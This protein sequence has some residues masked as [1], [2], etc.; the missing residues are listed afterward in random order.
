[1]IENFLEF[2]KS[3][4]SYA[5]LL[6]QF[7]QNFTYFRTFYITSNSC[8]KSNSQFMWNFLDF[9]VAKQSFFKKDVLLNKIF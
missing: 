7:S 5:E 1:M 4:H 6:N 8:E 9:E 2:L 3:V